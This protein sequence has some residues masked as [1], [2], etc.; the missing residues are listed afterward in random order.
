MVYRR[1]IMYSYFYMCILWRRFA[2]S[3]H[4]KVREEIAKTILYGRQWYAS[5]ALPKHTTSTTTWWFQPSWKICLLNLFISSRSEKS[6]ICETIASRLALVA[7]EMMHSP[8]TS[9]VLQGITIKVVGECIKA[10]DR[11]WCQRWQHA[12]PFYGWRKK[13]LPYTP[14]QEKI[15]PIIN[16]NIQSI[17]GLR[18]WVD[19][20]IHTVCSIQRRYWNRNTR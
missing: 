7:C 13:W 2:F 14:T 5:L 10:G 18:A 6:K 17:A 15:F 20:N 8:T 16:S 3:W 19:Y 1:Y 4:F 12:R 11:S 9:I